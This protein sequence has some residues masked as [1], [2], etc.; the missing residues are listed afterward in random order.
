MSD[1]AHSLQLCNKI[2]EHFDPTDPS[3]VLVLLKTLS[4]DDIEGIFNILKS[5]SPQPATFSPLAAKDSPSRTRA[6]NNAFRT[7]LF[8]AILTEQSLFQPLIEAAA[9]T[10][11][12][13]ACTGREAS[14]L[15]AEINLAL[16]EKTAE[17]LS[18]NGPYQSQRR[19]GRRH[20]TRDSFMHS[21]KC[22][23]SC[24]VQIVRSI[25]RCVTDALRNEPTPVRPHPE[26][27]ELTPDHLVALDLLPAL[28][29]FLK[30]TQRFV[31][32]DAAIRR[33]D[34]GP[35]PHSMSNSGGGRACSAGSREWAQQQLNSLLMCPWPPA[36]LLPMVSFFVDEG[37]KWMGTS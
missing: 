30:Q 26:E 23:H 27:D 35:T 5:R 15:V 37:G 36:L 32:A 8:K 6:A 22:L 34:A 24:V 13:R 10:V 1:H 33:S 4:T 31:Q 16:T 21:M 18:N 28:L 7:T 9:A 29:H 19:V 11:L 20:Q 12:H 2:V 14:S 3:D 17:F 25:V